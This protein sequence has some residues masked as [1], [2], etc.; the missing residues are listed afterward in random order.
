MF[1]DILRNEGVGGSN[2]SCGTSQHSENIEVHAANPAPTSDEKGQI[3]PTKSHVASAK[4]H[5]NSHGLTQA[6]LK[7]VLHYDPLTGLFTW[8]VTKGN[9]TAGTVAGCPANSEGYWRITIDS[10][11]YYAHRLAFLYML[12]RWPFEQA[13]HYPDPTTSNNRW[14]NLRD[15]THGQNTAN[16]HG[17]SKTGFK[18]VTKTKE[19]NSGRRS[20]TRARNTTLATSTPLKRRTSPIS[21]P[22]TSTTANTQISRWRYRPYDASSVYRRKNRRG[23]KPGGSNVF[24]LTL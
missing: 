4:S 17:E 23:T 18:G 7:E 3:S 16:T 19:G 2:P 12:G 11:K 6:R 9:I 21:S 5:G 10:V 13:D 24:E 14:A 20:C 1:D 22:R 15:A 8:R